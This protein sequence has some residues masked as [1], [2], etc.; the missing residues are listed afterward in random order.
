VATS[1]GGRLLRCECHGNGGPPSDIWHLYDPIKE[2]PF[3]FH[4]PDEC[5]CL[6]DLRLYKVLDKELFLCS[7]CWTGQEEVVIN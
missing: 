3:V 6:N 4:K 7:V 2:L 1:P 5:K